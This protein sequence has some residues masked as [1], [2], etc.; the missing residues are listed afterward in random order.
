[1]PAAARVINTV[2]DEPTAPTLSIVEQTCTT[3]DNN[4]GRVKRLIQ[5]H[6]AAAK[7]T[8]NE[9]S[10]HHTPTTPATVTLAPEAN[11]DSG[12]S[13]QQPPAGVDDLRDDG[14]TEAS[15]TATPTEVQAVPDARAHCST[16][17]SHVWLTQPRPSSQTQ[18]FHKPLINTKR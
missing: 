5:F 18:I 8:S 16:A 12:D 7:C 10:L 11:A 3:T 6:E 15:G 9:T 1:M 4:V 17:S 13:D 14:N 2:D